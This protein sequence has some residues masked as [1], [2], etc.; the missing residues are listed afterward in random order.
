M[1]R[2]VYLGYQNI[3]EGG[4][5]ER[6]KLRIFWKKISKYYSLENKRRK[7]SLKTWQRT[8]LEVVSFP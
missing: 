5:N 3:G 2:A 7:I 4:K 8:L 6:K 1:Y